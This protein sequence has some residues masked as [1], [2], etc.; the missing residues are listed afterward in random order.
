MQTKR[1]L[2]KLRT[3]SH[4]QIQRYNYGRNNSIG[5]LQNRNPQVRILPGP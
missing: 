1:L 5:K 3:N 4:F 2:G